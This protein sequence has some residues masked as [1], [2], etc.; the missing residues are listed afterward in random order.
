MH[1]V[2]LQNACINISISPNRQLLE[3]LNCDIVDIRGIVQDTVF[4]QVMEHSDYILED[5]EDLEMIK[6]FQFPKVE[7]FD[8]STMSKRLEPYQ[9]YAVMASG[10]SV[11]QHPTLI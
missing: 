8:F 4:G 1:A 7:W 11:F 2:P 5:C 6:Q 9:E 3:K 10:A